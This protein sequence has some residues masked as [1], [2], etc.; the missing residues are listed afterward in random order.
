M[1]LQGLYWLQD[2]AGAHLAPAP[3]IQQGQNQEGAH[4]NTSWLAMGRLDKREASPPP[5][6]QQL[7][8][9]TALIGHFQAIKQIDQRQ[10]HLCFN[11][12]SSLCVVF[13]A[14]EGTHGYT[15]A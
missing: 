11:F 15:R 6:G 1:K 7:A 2:V 3:E 13:Q 9:H 4:G 8:A 14:L 10:L 12:A 5:P